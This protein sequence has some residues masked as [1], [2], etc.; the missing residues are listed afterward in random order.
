MEPQR[1]CRQTYPLILGR[2]R[3]VM[4][5]DAFASG[6]LGRYRTY[7]P[8]PQDFDPLTARPHAL[9]KH[10]LPPRPDLRSEPKLERMWR[11]AV[12]LSP[13]Y[14]KAELAIDSLM[15][16][17]DPLL[18]AAKD[19]EFGPSNWGGVFVQTNGAKFVYA[20]WVVPAVANFDPAL[21]SDVIAGFW[22]GID[23]I[24][25]EVGG[26]QL[27]QAGIRVDV[28]PLGGSWPPVLQ[29]V[30]WRVWTEWWSQEFADDPRAGAVYVSNF[31]V[32]AGDTVS[33]LVCA[34]QPDFGYVWISNF[35]TG[36]HTSVGI[37]A[38]PQ[39]ASVGG[40]VEWIVEAPSGS[41]DLP[42][43]SPVT[44]NSCVGG[45]LG[46]QLHNVWH[47]NVVDID[48]SN[49]KLTKTSITSDTSVVVEWEGWS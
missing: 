45:S 14:I 8:P 47:G 37:D 27:L 21:F 31:P 2:D 34:E 35:S 17:R 30:R 3:T 38:L 28:N 29:P 26:N 5:E 9:R 46:G 42:L 6:A 10:G 48:G 22:V 39:I 1:A 40:T 18:R 43:F 12:S 15:S 20:E 16:A 7:D 41:P 25:F 33:F 13:N 4:N 32:S 36:Q 19:N 49:G 44:F 11:H 24:A 23:G